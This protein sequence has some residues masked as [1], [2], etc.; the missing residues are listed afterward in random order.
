MAALVAALALA[1]QVSAQTSLW[2]LPQS[3]TC[4][5]NAWLWV[6]PSFAVTAAGLPPPSNLALALARAQAAILAMP[7]GEAPGPVT[8]ELTSIVV[9][10]LN[11]TATPSLS[12]NE[13]Y[14]L[15][16]GA[17]QAVLTG[18]PLGCMQGLTTFL[19]LLVNR[20]APASCSV[21]DA[22]AFPYR[23][24]MVDTARYFF[25]A[26]FVMRIIDGMAL[27]KLNVLHWHITDSQ[28]FPLEVPSWPQLST[29]GA[30]V[31]HS[32]LCAASR[33]TYTVDEVRSVAAYGLQRG[34]R[35]LIETDTP[36]HCF[37][38]GKGY[39]GI[40]VDG[41]LGL[42][43]SDSIPLDPSNATAREVVRGVM[44]D[45]MSL[46]ADEAYFIGGDEIDLKCWE[47]TPHIRAWLQ[48]Q[49]LTAAEAYAQMVAEAASNAAAG[50]RY[51]MAWEDV[52]ATAAWAANAT[53][54][55][56]TGTGV[57]GMTPTST[58]TTA[59]A[60]PHGTLLQLPEDTIVSVWRDPANLLGITRGSG[61]RTVLAAGWYIG[62]MFGP[63][64]ASDFYA[65]TFFAGANATAWTPALRQRVVGGGAS[66]WGK[67]GLVVE[68]TTER[69]FD[70][71]VW[72]PLLAVA[73]RL[74]SGDGTPEWAVSAARAQ[75]QV[76]RMRARGFNVTDVS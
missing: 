49:S 60:N 34:I 2:P 42:W 25:S 43:N 30:F 50:G 15:E 27:N 23:A 70:G 67:S 76:V 10:V 36:G 40:A 58:T 9:Q 17:G 61:L 5:P 22:P 7:S 62:D 3:V 56:V 13:S 29:A 51:A 72:A 32:F 31:P 73:E 11:G 69:L 21:A 52:L 26:E 41:C 47:D 53:E 19:Q 44:S 12:A 24:F 37:A 54:A 39:P 1:E 38:W 71:L 64:R 74:W 63:S 45:V 33:C 68:P 75:A 6:P 8:G 14:T 57:R 35:V 48:S 55:P 20:T 18:E 4:A 16:V 59:T 46:T 28:S 65:Q 66:K